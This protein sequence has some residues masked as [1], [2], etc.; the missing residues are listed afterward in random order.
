[1]GGAGT[2]VVGFDLDN[3]KITA[4]YPLDRY[5]KNGPSVPI[6]EGFCK[7]RDFPSCFL[8]YGEFLSVY[9][10]LFGVDSSLGYLPSHYPTDKLTVHWV[11]IQ[12]SESSRL[13]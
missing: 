3:L 8:P 1:M 10:F 9:Q 4:H 2:H 13:D 5:P 7:I 12:E 6:I 11:T